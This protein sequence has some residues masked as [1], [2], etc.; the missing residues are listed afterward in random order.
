MFRYIYIIYL[1]IVGEKPIRRKTHPAAGK[2]PAINHD[3]FQILSVEPENAT[4]S[5]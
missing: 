1:T 2:E 5:P 4:P 3:K